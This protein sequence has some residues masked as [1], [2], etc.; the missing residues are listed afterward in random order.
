MTDDHLLF[1]D[2][3]NQR[4]EGKEENVAAWKVF[5]S[6][7]PDYRNIFERF[8]EKDD[9]VL[10]EGYSTCTSKPLDGPALWLIKF[11]GEK[12]S[13]WKVY[14]DTPKNRDALGV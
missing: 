3:D 10:V 9:T 4:V 1:I 5:F 11:Q 2:D 7:F 14:I 12:L 13:E 8:T 6:S